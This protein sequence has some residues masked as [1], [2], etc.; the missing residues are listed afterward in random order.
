MMAL[1]A[2]QEQQQYNAVRDMYIAQGARVGRSTHRVFTKGRGDIRI[3]QPVNFSLTFAEEPIFTAGL[4][5]HTG[6]LVD[7]LY[8]LATVGVYQWKKDSRGMYIG[9][10]IWASVS[11]GLNA[12]FAGE[13]FLTN[14]TQQ[15][16]QGKLTGQS[17]IDA[18]GPITGVPQV[19]EVGPHIGVPMADA[20]NYTISQ[21]RAA[22]QANQYQLEHHLVFEALAIRD[23]NYDVM[24]S[25]G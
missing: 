13:A 16:Q 10:Y 3:A 17:L 25:D 7:H 18:V 20:S 14:S 9:A 11:Q 1:T 24:M 4:A 23:I 8:P 5:L 19:D 21:A 12:E 6:S 2:W 15:Y 22:Q